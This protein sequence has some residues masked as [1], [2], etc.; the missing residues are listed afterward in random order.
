MMERDGRHKDGNETAKGRGEMT[1]KE[2]YRS[3]RK[4]RRERLEYD[5]GQNENSRIDTR[6]GTVSHAHVL[7]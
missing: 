4:R 2:E 3:G 7:E 1:E 6:D 5:G